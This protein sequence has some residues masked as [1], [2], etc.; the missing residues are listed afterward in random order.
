MKKFC[1]LIQMVT[2]TSKY[3]CYLFTALVRINISFKLL[4][5]SF[6]NYHAFIPSLESATVFCT[7][8]VS[9]FFSLVN[10]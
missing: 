1:K 5:C 8:F 3:F 7:V 4:I 2:I 10:N 6:K 9:T